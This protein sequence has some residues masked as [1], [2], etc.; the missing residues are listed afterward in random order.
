[1]DNILSATGQG[2]INIALIK[3]WGKED[4]EEIVPLNNSISLTLDM[5]NFYTKTTAFLNLEIQTE[6]S[7]LFINSKYFILK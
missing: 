2:A 7:N 6:D 1:M 5:S 3:Y 4:E